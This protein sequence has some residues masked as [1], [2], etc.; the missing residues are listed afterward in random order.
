MEDNLFL[1]LGGK[2]EKSRVFPLLQK[3]FVYRRGEKETDKGSK[4]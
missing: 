3:V 2:K 4:V 1:G